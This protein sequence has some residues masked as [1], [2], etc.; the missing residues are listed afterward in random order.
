MRPNH[1]AHGIHGTSCE[2]AARLLETL[3]HLFRVVRVFRGRPSKV[4]AG[5]AEFAFPWYGWRGSEKGDAERSFFIRAI[6]V[7][8]G[9]SL[10]HFDQRNDSHSRRPLSRFTQ[11]QDV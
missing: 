2:R 9:Q 1:G 4:F 5:K 11:G 7:I 10:F 6:R 8:R 3:R